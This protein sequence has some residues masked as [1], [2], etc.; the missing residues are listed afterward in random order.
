MVWD[1]E[2]EEQREVTVVKVKQVGVFFA[3]DSK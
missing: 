1:D 2:N 3:G